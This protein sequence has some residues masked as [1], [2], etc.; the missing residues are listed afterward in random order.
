MSKL[1]EKKVAAIKADLSDG[2]TQP[3]VAK[4]HRTSRSTVSDIATE[5][6]HRKVPWPDGEA[7][8]K[9]PGGQRRATPK[10]DPNNDR[11]K[12][13]EAEVL[14][15][16]EE[17]DHARKAARLSAK[18]RGIYKAVVKEMETRV[19][20]FKALPLARDR[21]T[22]NDAIEEH[23]VMHLS[24]GHHDQIVTREES[25]GLE[26]Y[27]FPIS[28]RRAEQY[29][30]T[31]LDWTQETL[32]PRFN[33]KVCTILAYGD[34]TSGEIHGHVS[35][36]YFRNQFKNCFA[37]AQLHALMYRDLAPHFDAVNVVYLPG[38]HGRRS[39]KKDYHGAHDN[40]DYLIAE[41]ARLHCRDIENISFL[42]PNSFSVNVD[43]NGVG[44]NLS[45][46]DDVQGSLGIPFYGM[47]RRQKGLIAL[48]S[49][50][51]GGQRIRYFCMGHHHVQGALA[52]IDGELVLNGAWPGTD[53]YSYNRFV[54]FREPS[55][56]IHGV[57]PKHGITWRMNVHLRSPDEAKGPRRYKIEL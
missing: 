52:D 19:H 17:R 28:C 55:Q 20:P 35:R 30:D 10:F 15:L 50:A 41:M 18:E 4:K 33:F 48:N 51:G 9:R 32:S 8:V 24:D 36:S 27:N 25:G 44:F 26:E 29:V 1:T 21:R 2:M 37:I 39:V 7:P 43:I 6:I 49:M 14:H 5:R 45:H 38:N 12:D 22:K 34:H 56:L 3:A 23:V 16:R 11:I 46:G 31:L 40:W 57:N 53:S 54:G 13:L 47:V 42:I